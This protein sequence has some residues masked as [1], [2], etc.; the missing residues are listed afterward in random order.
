MYLCIYDN[1]TGT[2]IKGSRV[3]GFGVECSGFGGLGGGSFG[4]NNI[5]VPR[6]SD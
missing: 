4:R 1:Y 3:L 5:T 2:V 6:A